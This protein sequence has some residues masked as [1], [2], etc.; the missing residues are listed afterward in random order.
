MQ[1][2]PL[3]LNVVGFGFEPEYTPLKPKLAEPPADSVEFQDGALAVTCAPS[4]ETVAFQAWPAFW[5]PA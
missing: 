2:V 5:F 1:V 3:S 4:W